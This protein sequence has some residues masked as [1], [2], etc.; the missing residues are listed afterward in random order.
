MGVSQAI[1]AIYATSGYNA[2]YKG[3]SAAYMRESVYTSTRI[4]LYEH[5]KKLVGATGKDSTLLQ[6]FAAGALSGALGS[7]LG[8]PFDVLKTRM[9]ADA[10]S[11]LSVFTHISDINKNS[12]FKGFYKGLDANIMRA[13]VLN[14]TK[15][16]VYD[17]TK[18]AIN[19]VFN[20]KDGIILQTLSSGVAGF[21]MACTVTPF[22]ML[23]TRLMNKSKDGEVYKNLIDA[24][25]KVSKKEGLGAIYKGFIPV[26][27]RFAPTT[28]LQLIIFE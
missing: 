27:G 16:G 10:E 8:N 2:F 15:M 5:A 4:G 12:G 6:K 13:M 28:T 26:W 11:R 7:I 19:K 21:F 18:H 24:F 22:D 25:V 23:R 9:M 1:K 20:L 3:L 14:A 17:S